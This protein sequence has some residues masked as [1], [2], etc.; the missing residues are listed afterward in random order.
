MNAVLP[1]SF[2]LRTARMKFLANP[3]EMDL[4]A[5]ARILEAAA[6]MER[7]TLSRNLRSFLREGPS[8]FPDA[9]PDWFSNRDQGL[10]GA[11]LGAAKKILSG[12]AGFE[13]AE[14]IAQ[15]MAIGLTP[16]GGERSD[17]YGDVGKHHGQGILDGSLKPAQVKTTLWGLAQR[18]A[19][20]VWR[21][22]KRR[23]QE[24]ITP[25]E[26]GAAGSTLDA[27]LDRSPLEVILHL[28][29][30]EHGREFRNWMYKALEGAPAAQRVAM[31]I[32]FEY[33]T[34]HQ[35]WPSGTDVYREYMA[36]MGQEAPPID[37]TK[38]PSHAPG[39]RTFTMSRDRAIKFIKEKI[40]QNPKVLDWMDR[41]LDLAALGYG[42]GQLRLA[43]SIK[44]V[45][46]R[47]LQDLPVRQ[48]SEVENAQKP[49]EWNLMLYKSRATRWDYFLQNP[50]G[51]GGGTTSFTSAGAAMRAALSRTMFK[52]AT[53][54]WV[55]QAVWDAEAEDYRITKTFWQPL[56]V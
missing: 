13:T 45:A 1:P 30:S 41:Y 22:N 52:G 19:V 56:P 44:R 3:V 50:Q 17:I 39:V 8:Q 32:S 20:D 49:G 16:S 37:P 9:N 46:G 21:K 24:E 55:I 14:E 15:N 51:G 34:T 36:A 48:A 54:V 6:G 18:R 47:Y 29:T 10:A 42:G 43:K 31:E 12:E 7:W 25:G 33:L 11:V 40:E 5:R 38:P 27:V 23:R 53:R 28:V 4:Y 2:L 35:K 26:E